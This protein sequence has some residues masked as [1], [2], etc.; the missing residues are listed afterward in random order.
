MIQLE[1]KPEIE[2]QLNA[3]ARASG[4]EV[5][6]Y[7]ESL[8]SEQEDRKRSFDPAAVAKAIDGLLEL[9]RHTSPGPEAIK[10]LINEGRKY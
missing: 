4:L 9:R 5:E 1:L 8:I 6:G 2:A 7:V 10:D 3:Q